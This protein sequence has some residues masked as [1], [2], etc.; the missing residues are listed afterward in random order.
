MTSQPVARHADPTEAQIA[1]QMFTNLAYGAMQPR[2]VQPLRRRLASSISGS[3]Y[4]IY[5]AASE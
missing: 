5:Q 2:A 4:K 3:P 1:W